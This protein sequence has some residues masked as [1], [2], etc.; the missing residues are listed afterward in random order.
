MGSGYFLERKQS[1]QRIPHARGVRSKIANARNTFLHRGKVS[2][3]PGI[4]L[5]LLF[6]IYIPATL[7][8]IVISPRGAI[9]YLHCKKKKK[10]RIPQNR[11]ILSASQLIYAWMMSFEDHLLLLALAVVP[12]PWFILVIITRSNWP[13]VLIDTWLNCP[14]SVDFL[15]INVSVAFIYNFLIG[16]SAA[17]FVWSCRFAE[18][19]EVCGHS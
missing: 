10:K 8:C 16:N 2:G 15:N 12:S 18:S 14:A 9:V 4:R 17:V 3:N 6:A 19:P 11:R 7:R 13:V 1:S 5:A